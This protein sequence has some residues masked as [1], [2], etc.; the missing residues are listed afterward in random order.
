MNLYVFILVKERVMGALM[1]VHVI[2][3]DTVSLS[4]RIDRCL[5]NLVEMKYLLR[6]TCIYAFWPK[7]PI[8]VQLTMLFRYR[9]HRD[10]NDVYTI[11][12]QHR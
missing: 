4:Y 9:R 1:H 2:C 6:C 11:S 10:V 7:L 8:H 12:C 3:E 5:R